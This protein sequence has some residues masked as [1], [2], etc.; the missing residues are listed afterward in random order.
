MGRGVRIPQTRAGS[1]GVGTQGSRLHSP[2]L[3]GPS[4]PSSTNHVGILD[5]GSLPRWV[6]AP[7]RPLPLAPS[8]VEAGVSPR[9]V[10]SPQ[11]SVCCCRRSR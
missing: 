5:P 11:V 7:P 4:S 3:P 10:L 9:A 1:A 6:R 8:E 2:S